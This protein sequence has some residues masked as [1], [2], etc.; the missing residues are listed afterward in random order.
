AHIAYPSTPNFNNFKTDY[1]RAL[2]LQLQGDAAPNSDEHIPKS[3]LPTK[4]TFFGTVKLHGTNATI[5]FRD[6]NRFRPQ[7]QSRSW[8]IESN[9]KDNLGTYALL[10]AAPL[11]SLVDQILA[12]RGH[13]SHFEEIYV[14]GEI[15]GKGVQKDVAIGALER[16]FAIFNI[17]IDGRWVD[18][19]QYK[20]CSLPE[21]RVYNTAQYRTFE[22]DI[23]F[24]VETTVI[25]EQMDQYTAEVCDECPFGAAFVDTA[26]TQISG[27][28]EG[29]VWTMVQTLF[30]NEGGAFDATTLHNFKTKGEKFATTSTPR[31]RQEN[32]DP[33]VS[34]ATVQFANYALGERRFEQGIEYLEAKQTHDGKLVDAYDIKLTGAFIKWVTEDAVKEERNEMERLGVTETAAK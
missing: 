5:V 3:R 22:I 24:Q 33:A 18:M 29:I 2:N 17:R 19:R 32:N 4:A 34:D 28:G 8:I 1:V 10:S 25:S 16:F 6:G 20:S 9:R 15:A 14:C 31:N 23:D 30:M 12:V 7:I 27:P 26:G 21:Y 13:G 11:Y